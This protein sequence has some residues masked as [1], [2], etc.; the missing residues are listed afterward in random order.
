L[1]FRHQKALSD[2]A[3]A[4]SALMKKFQ[5][6]DTTNLASLLSVV[7]LLL[8]CFVMLC[9][10]V[11]CFGWS[12][13]HCRQLAEECDLKTLTILSRYP[14]AAHSRL[15]RASAERLKAASCKTR[16]Q[17][18][19]KVMMRRM[20]TKIQKP[21]SS[22]RMLA[23]PELLVAQSHCAIRRPPTVMQLE[24]FQE[25]QF[26]FI[27]NVSSR[28]AMLTMLSMTRCSQSVI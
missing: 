21:T 22:H 8:F 11:L 18:T 3:G 14:T 26:T 25:V 13:Q 4:L 12:C 10:V 5:Y 28:R 1:E 16:M 17:V 9:F 2:A 24:R 15:V 23:H 20:T 19:T 7:F 27:A 6:F